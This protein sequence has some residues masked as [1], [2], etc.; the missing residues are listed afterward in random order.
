MFERK[1][2]RR[3]RKEGLKM[4]IKERKSS[5]KER[6]K[7]GKHMPVNC[8]QKLNNNKKNY[9][10]KETQKEGKKSVRTFKMI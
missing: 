9:R 7:E 5:I 3:E 6:R 2:I 10:K 8:K 1:E 4:T